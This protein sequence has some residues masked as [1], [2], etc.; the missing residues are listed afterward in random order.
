MNTQF[1][2]DIIK[3]LKQELYK[4]KKKARE[5]NPTDD[6]QLYYNGVIVGLQV[7]IG[8]YE[9]WLYNKQP[10]AKRQHKKRGA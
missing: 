6:A 10:K 5:L 1:I 8:K 4:A 7:S 3:D 2:T 9:Q